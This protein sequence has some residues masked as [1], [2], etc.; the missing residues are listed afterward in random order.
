MKKPVGH[1]RFGIVCDSTY[2][3]VWQEEVIKKLISEAHIE[4]ELLVCPRKRNNED[5][6]IK[7]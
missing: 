7:L 6:F 5:Y 2:V 4:L 1:I 3:H